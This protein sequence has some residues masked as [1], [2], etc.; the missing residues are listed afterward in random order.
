MVRAFCI[1]QVA[2]DGAVEELGG[3]LVNSANIDLEKLTLG[4][5]LFYVLFGSEGVAPSLNKN[6]PV[7]ESRFIRDGKP[8]QMRATP[9]E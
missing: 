8:R 7:S 9:E 4:E 5:L 1:L 3:A 6:E 2:H